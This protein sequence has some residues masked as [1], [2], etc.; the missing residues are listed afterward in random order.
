M[1]N[2]KIKLFI[3]A[4]LTLMCVFISCSEPTKYP[5]Y[6]LETIEYVPDSLKQEHRTWITET[7]R[8][9]S[10]HMTGG[11][12]EDIDETIRQAKWTADDLFEVSV[13]GLR[14]KIDR[15]LRNDLHLKPSELNA[16]EIKILDSLS[17]N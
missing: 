10:Q 15:N 17:D 13:I 9:A 5:I 11:D 1:R 8:A 3:L 2:L 6:T 4:C 16:H 12:Y 7:V 14:K